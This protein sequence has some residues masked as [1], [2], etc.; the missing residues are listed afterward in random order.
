[1]T[2][3]PV[4]HKGD[5]YYREATLPRPERE[6][7]ETLAHQIPTMTIRDNH[8]NDAYYP[9][10]PTATREAQQP[11]ALLVPPGSGAPQHQGLHPDQDVFEDAHTTDEK[12]EAREEAQNSRGA[13]K[14]G[15]ARLEPR[16]PRRIGGGDRE[17]HLQPTLT[18]PFSQPMG[19]K[20]PSGT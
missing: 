1:M 16:Q 12:P 6:A 14:R 15:G 9:K 17:Q 8:T 13:T 2:T 7:E 19:G 4:E 20:T 3:Q 18:R 10:G 11:T 5:T